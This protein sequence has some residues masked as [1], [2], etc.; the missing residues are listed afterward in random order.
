[1]PQ[2]VTHNIG[3]KLLAL[4]I[5]LLVYA[6]VATE[7]IYQGFIHLSV[8][9]DGIP[10]NLV[11]VAEVPD[12]I[13]VEVRGKTKEL[14]RLKFSKKLT[15]HIDLSG[16][17][18]GDTEI[19]LTPRNVYLPSTA[20]LRIVNVVSPSTLSLQL[21]TKQRKQVPVNPYIT[22][23]PAPGW[24]IVGVPDVEPDRVWVEA[25]EDVTIRVEEI[26]TDPV[27]VTDLT[28]SLSKR[29]GLV[30]PSGTYLGVSPESVVVT[31]SIEGN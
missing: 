14:L 3:M 21:A 19:P 12:S 31:V 20:D 6:H 24:R 17:R 29:V 1:M 18:P 28:R 23:R 4:L 30:L 10:K 2:W 5:A 27:D 11:P 9:L 26:W 16:A 7:R 25:V 13:V 8:V 15:A 22:G